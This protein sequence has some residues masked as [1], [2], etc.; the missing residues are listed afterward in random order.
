M[1]AGLTLMEMAAEITRQQALKADYIMDTR[2]IQLEPAGSQMFMNVLDKDGNMAVE[3]LEI[4]QLTHR[5][6][7][8]E[9]SIPA[10]FYDRMLEHHPDLLAHN[11]NALFQKRKWKTDSS[12]PLRPYASCSS[13]VSTLPE[14]VS[15]PILPAAWEISLIIFLQKA[16]FMAASW[17]SR[18]IRLPTIYI[19]MPIFPGRISVPIRQAFALIIF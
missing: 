2:R 4:N 12:L 1:K 18:P 11:V 17:I 5:Q 19:Q 9:L 13:R 15:W 6:I 16:M 10:A 8:T 14:E 7:G 3:P